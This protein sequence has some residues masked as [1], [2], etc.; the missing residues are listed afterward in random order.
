M[1]LSRVM[2]KIVRRDTVIVQPELHEDNQD[3]RLRVLNV[4][5]NSKQIPIPDHYSGWNHL[6]LDIAP[7]PDVDVLLDA[8]KLS[9]YDGDKFDSIYSSHNLEHF[10]PH[11]VP[12]VLSGFLEV[13]KPDGFVDVRVPDITSVLKA[14]V[15]NGMELDDVLY[16]SPAGPISAHDV[17]YGWGAEIERSG[18]DFFAHK[19]G[20]SAKSLSLSLEKAGFVQVHTVVSNFEVRALAF[21]TDP[22]AEQRNALGI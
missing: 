21:K 1:L 3:T 6:L 17:I 4:G 9:D 2:K 14:V 8:R 11:D 5:G 20:F 19:R 12:K 7:G 16:I 18:V 22:T 13:L 10:Y 15:D